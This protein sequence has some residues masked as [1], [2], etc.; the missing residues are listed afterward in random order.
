MSVNIVKKE[1]FL[2]A[3]QNKVI[4]GRKLL[5]AGNHHWASRLFLDLYFEIETKEWLDVQKKHQLIMILSNSWWMYINSLKIKRKVKKFDLI[6]YTDAYKRFFSF[7]SKLEDFSLFDKFATD[8]LKNFIKLEN[9]SIEG[10]TK[11]VN[12][13][14]VKVIEEKNNLKLIELQILLM[15][16]RKSVIPT[17]YFRTSMENLGRII[18]KLEPGKR[19]L[20]LFI[21]LE[22]VNLKFILIEDSEEFI[23]EINK[24]LVNRIPN[25]LKNDFSNLSRISIN[26]RTFNTIQEDLKSLIEYLNNIG[27]PS[28]IIIVIRS[29]FHNMK[30]YL[31]LGDAIVQ[32]RQFINYTLDR[33]RFDISYEIYDF[34]EDLFLIQSDLGYDN[35]LIE[36]WAEACKKFGNMKEKK[37]LLQSIEKLT[38]NLKIPEKPPQIYHYFYTC[39]YLWKFKSMF[40]YTEKQDFWRMLFYRA[41]YEENNMFLAK[42]IVPFLNKRLHPLLSNIEK[43]HNET[44]ELQKLIYTLDDKNNELLYNND[45]EIKNII[46]R[47]NS[48]GE[49]SYRILSI[50]NNTLEGVIYDEYWNDTHIIDIYNE[51]FSDIQNKEY[52]LDLKEFGTVLYLLLPK[53]IRKF[54]SQ[55]KIRSIEYTPQIYFIIDYMTI[56]FELIYDGN[57]FFLKYS[58]GYNIGEP[59]IHGVNFLEEKSEVIQPQEELKYDVLVIDS[60]NALGPTRWNDDIKNKELLFPFPAGA[61]ELNFISEFFNQCKEINSIDIL[62]G[63]ESIKR[64]I[65]ETI[66]KRPHKI[67]YIVGNIFY[68]HL[69]PRNS[70]FITND[71]N[72]IKF[73]ELFNAISEEKNYIKPILFFNTQ[74]YDSIGNQIQDDI[75]CF[76]EIISQFEFTHITGVISRVFPIFNDETK[77]IIANI[78]INLF[79]HNSLGISLLK[80]RQEYIANKTTQLIEKQMTQ[81]NDQKENAH[82]NIENSQAI[83]SF[84][85]YGEPWRKL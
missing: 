32:I 62:T 34:L 16:L 19:S 49:I 80:A 42:R 40:F 26:E 85:L 31:S 13:F 65:L 18:Y 46:I 75:R 79:N 12:S 1:E 82:I 30:K 8:L 15:F 4:Q 69:N 77:N 57:F 81:I 39:N 59:P 54:L 28:W 72:I 5:Q 41:L 63:R 66:S 56:P 74:I 48:R 2:N 50:D 11:F 58:C 21:I 25:Y 83:S 73:T 9:L 6:K 53:L 78:F 76:G 51:I 47:I 3:F 33:N 60:I 7:L 70:Y 44:K 64:N 17:D 45:F 67:I 43:L 24:I 35:V 52:D 22:S 10:I 37:F 36:L 61:N 55:F 23:K 71:N 20:F 29:L 68:S 27:E 38:D 14:S 84:I